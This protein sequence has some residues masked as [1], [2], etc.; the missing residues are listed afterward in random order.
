MIE[1]LIKRNGTKSKSD[2]NVSACKLKVSGEWIIV[3]MRETEV[4]IYRYSTASRFPRG[5][6]FHSA[7]LPAE[8][9][10]RCRLRDL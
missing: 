7:N 4:F 6:N 1:A 8:S 5:C 3:Y 9:V 10:D 2:A